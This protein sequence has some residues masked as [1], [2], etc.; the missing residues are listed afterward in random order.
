MHFY[1]Y[2]NPSEVVAVL[3]QAKPILGFP[4]V[5][6]KL[7]IIFYSFPLVWKNSPSKT[8]LSFGAYGIMLR[9]KEQIM[10]FNYLISQQAQLMQTNRLGFYNSEKFSSPELPT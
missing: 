5:G 3:Q 9:F 1:N 8:S 6:T 4:S 7:T 10:A 2:M